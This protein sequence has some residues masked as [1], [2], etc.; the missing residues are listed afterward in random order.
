M[1]DTNTSKLQP[2]NTQP[3]FFA[4][5]LADEPPSEW[6]RLVEEGVLAFQ[7]S[8]DGAVGFTSESE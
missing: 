7:S 4:D 3:D 8:S 2:T 1:L 6:D 5:R